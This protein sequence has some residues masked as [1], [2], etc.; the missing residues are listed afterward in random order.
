MCL[1]TETACQRLQRHQGKHIPQ[2]PTPKG[3]RSRL[4]SYADLV[5]GIIPGSDDGGS[6][7]LTST[8]TSSVE[9]AKSHN[10]AGSAIRY[11]EALDRLKEGIT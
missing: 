6:L 8:E 1:K 5:E 7:R 4:F 10:S 3:P 9:T 2:P 11:L